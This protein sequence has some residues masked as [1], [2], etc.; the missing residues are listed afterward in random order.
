[1]LI[2][3]VSPEETGIPVQPD[4]IYRLT[5]KEK[6]IIDKILRTGSYKFP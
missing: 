1:M 5:P 6:E 3:N 2:T 4:R